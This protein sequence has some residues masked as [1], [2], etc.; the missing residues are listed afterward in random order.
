MAKTVL[1]PNVSKLK[2]LS[3]AQ[4]IEKLKNDAGINVKPSGEEFTDIQVKGLD[5]FLDLSAPYDGSDFI[6]HF[7]AEKMKAAFNENPNFLETPKA[8]IDVFLQ[9]VDDLMTKVPIP[10]THEW[11][12]RF[13]L[14]FDK[15]NAYGIV[16]IPYHGLK[17]GKD[18]SE[19]VEKGLWTATNPFFA[20][21]PSLGII[22]T[23]VG[24]CRAVVE[25]KDPSGILLAYIALISFKDLIMN[26]AIGNYVK[27]VFCFARIFDD[28]NKLTIITTAFDAYDQFVIV[29]TIKTSIGICYDQVDLIPPPNAPVPDTS[30]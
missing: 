2:N 12:L 22:S 17:G 20:L 9:R 25:H 28:A 11:Y 1:A 7:R 10:L 14:G 4:I 8:L 16:V 29:N 6:T 21:V 30:L 3:T 24:Q 15:N 19:D 23:D 26:F 27:V 13:Y 5:A 18:H